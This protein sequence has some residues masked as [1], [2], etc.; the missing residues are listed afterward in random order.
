VSGFG[1]NPTAHHGNGLR[2]ITLS[3]ISFNGQG[4]KS[5]KTDL[6]VIKL[7]AVVNSGK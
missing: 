5:R 3:R 4:A 7:A 6:A 1:K 2:R